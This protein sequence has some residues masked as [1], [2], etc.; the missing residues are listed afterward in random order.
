MCVK[1]KCNFNVEKYDIMVI[2]VDSFASF[3]WFW[4]IFCYP[5]PDPQHWYGSGS[6]RPRWCWPDR[7]RIHIT[8]YNSSNLFVLLNS[9]S[10]EILPLEIFIL[11][12]INFSLK[13]NILKFRFWSISDPLFKLRNKNFRI[14]SSSD[15][16]SKHIQI[17]LFSVLKYFQILFEYSKRVQNWRFLT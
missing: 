6:G 14:R 3:P 17:K 7:I 2:P 16:N 11:Q 8:G 15:I 10:L 4:L 12:I 5:D 1:Q 9:D 13:K